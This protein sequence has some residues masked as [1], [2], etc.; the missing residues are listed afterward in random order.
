MASTHRVRTFG[1]SL[2]LLLAPA[3]AGAQRGMKA[4]VGGGGGAARGTASVPR[5]A[6]GPL[7]GFGTVL[8][9]GH[10]GPTWDGRRGGAWSGPRQGQNPHN[11]VPCFDG[12][13][14]CVGG[15]TWL[16]RSRTGYYAY[17]YA[18]GYDYSTAIPYQVPVYVPYPVAYPQPAYA[19]APAEPAKP[20]NPANSRMLTIGGGADGGGGAMRIE[21]VD[22]ATL[23]LTWLGSTRPVR[24][25]RLFL[26]DSLQQTLRAQP[27]DLTT[28]SALFKLTGLTPRVAYTGLTV[29]YADGATQTTLVPFAAS[30]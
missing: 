13:L 12:G 18:Y 2:L 30:K 19:A 5:P 6:P 3:W 25:A 23:R 28:P 8:Q 1:L 15:N 4:A 14:R 20:Y 24:E 16:G 27:V 10:R 9:G 17:P 7:T 22:T 29:I 11:F 21:C 26:A